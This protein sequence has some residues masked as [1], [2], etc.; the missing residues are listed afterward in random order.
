[1]QPMLTPPD[2]GEELLRERILNQ[3]YAF[4]EQ[5]WDKMAALLEDR[6]PHAIANPA[7]DTQAKPGSSLYKTLVLL[8]IGSAF[9]LLWFGSKSQ[10]NAATLPLNEGFAPANPN[11]PNTIPTTNTNSPTPA[12]SHPKAYPTPQNTTAKPAANLPSAGQKQYRED[13]PAT[14]TAPQPAQRLYPKGANRPGELKLAPQPTPVSAPQAN[15]VKTD[16][17]QQ[18]QTA[19]AANTTPATTPVEPAR[20]NSTSDIQAPA[21]HSEIP[22]SIPAA[23]RARQ[24]E[25]I[26]SPLA[27]L[28]PHETSLNLQQVNVAPP[29]ATPVKI[30]KKHNLQYHVLAGASLAA[31]DFNELQ[32]R[33]APHIGIGVS[34]TLIPGYRIQAELTGKI[35]K[36]YDFQSVLTDTI[37]LANGVGFRSLNFSGNTLQYIEMPIL[38]KRQSAEH[39]FN[40]FAGI[41][42][43]VNWSKG[44]SVNSQTYGYF[45]AALA[46]FNKVPENAELRRGLRRFDLGMVLGVECRITRNLSMNLRFNQGLFDLT[47]DNFFQ[48]RENTLNTDAQLSVQMSF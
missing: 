29:A 9:S 39:R 26:Q 47:H 45:Q 35:I 22:Q 42:P 24:I 13:L 16:L 41:R 43:S 36:G 10:S 21:P 1:M 7:S 23:L 12:V 28:T 38:I 18:V 31:V 14:E 2:N 11:A 4:D 20:D 33:W 27:A 40:W 17:D 30:Q 37:L 6:A 3:E 8:L 46:D 5:A 48:V 32:L 15:A 44:A 25:L 34:R 19:I